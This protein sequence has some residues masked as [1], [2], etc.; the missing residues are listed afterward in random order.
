MNVNEGNGIIVALDVGTIEELYQLVKDVDEHNAIHGYKLGSEL[1]EDEG[2]RHIMPVL[3]TI[4]DKPIIYDKQ[5]FGGDIPR[6]SKKQISRYNKRG[7]DYVITFPLAGIETLRTIGKTA[8]EL[9]QKLIVGGE[10][11]HDGYLVTHNGYITHEAAMRI[12]ADA[13][14][15]GVTDYVVPGNEPDEI[16]LIRGIIEPILGETTR[17]CYWAPGFVTQGGTLEDAKD[18]FGDQEWKAIMGSGIYGVPSKERL[19]AV[20]AYSKLI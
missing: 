1:I 4:T 2:L 16:K 17:I 8:K 14:S 10:M 15:M 18:V 7:L 11:T 19:A 5:K 12:Y 20:D 6:I 9:N 3:R 13:A